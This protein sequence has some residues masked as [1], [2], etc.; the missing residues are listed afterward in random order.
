MDKLLILDV[1]DILPSHPDFEVIGVFNPAVVLFQNQYIMIA[2]VAERW[3]SDD[4]G[5][6]KFPYFDDFGNLQYQTFEKEHFKDESSDKRIIKYLDHVF[7][8]SISHLR[9]FHSEDGIHFDFSKPAFL[10][11]EG[12]YEEY[13]IEDPRITNIDNVFYITYTAISRY[14]IAVRLMRTLDFIHFER[15]GNIF[16]AD[17][18]DCVIF[19]KKI[20]GDYFALHRPSISQFGRLD[21]W[22]AESQNLI[23][24]GNHKILF[25]ARINYEE[26]K[27][28]GA[29][30]VPI[31]TDKG[32]L[33][34]YHSADKSDHYHFSVML[35]DKNNPNVVLSKSKEPLVTP[36]EFYERSGFMNDVIFT[37]GLVEKEGCLW[38]YYGACDQ[39]IA[40][41]KVPME[42]VWNNMEACHV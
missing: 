40:L 42:V 36:T 30:A 41:C 11:P 16:H 18:K 22:T 14:G 3:T 2:R 19:P 10:F 39:S 24:W 9:V 15:M 32:W 33:E 17:N 20:N 5:F 38:I 35:L 8:S 23:N 37:C 26:S 29:G 27:R 6:V 21:I 25:D 1:K 34:V 4:S 7:L 28:I 31:L 13:G 12:V